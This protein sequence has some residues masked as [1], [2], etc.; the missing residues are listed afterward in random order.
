MASN[1]VLSESEIDALMETVG[2]DGDDSSQDDGEYRRVDFTA[3]KYAALREF[4]TLKA[5]TERQLELFDSAI[6]QRLSLP[7][8]VHV[9]PVTLLSVG[10]AL[11][12]LDRVLAVTTVSLQPLHTELFITSPVGLLSL[13][14]NHYFGGSS[15]LSASA[16]Q[17][18]SITPSE[19][20]LAE[21]VATLLT[22]SMVEAWSEKLEIQ[23]GEPGTLDF[24]ERIAALPDDE[25]LLRIGFRVSMEQTEG[26]IQ[27]LLPFASLEPFRSRL[28]PPRREKARDTASE[29]VW[30]SYMRRELPGIEIELAA[31]LASQRITLQELMQLNT[32]SIVPI[33]SPDTVTLSVDQTALAEG[34]YGAFDGA[35]A[36]QILR[37][38][39]NNGAA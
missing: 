24:P 9:E 31:V 23:A 34:R 20:R 15:N 21:R 30:E 4:T 29:G 7:C 39:S 32:G 12:G 5:L 3:R 27:M 17:R 6:H 28:A 10:D 8:E 11:A 35:K 16:T 1:D 18:E 38:L 33:S 26:V 13:F 22:E 2:D 14:V 37:L 25:I 19:L 36:V